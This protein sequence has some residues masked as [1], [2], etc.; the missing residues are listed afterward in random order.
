MKFFTSPHFDDIHPGSESD[1]KC[2]D[3]FIC[4]LMYRPVG[5]NFQ[6]GVR[7]LALRDAHLAERGAIA[8]ESLG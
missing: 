2:V 7:R 5:R 3:V 6:R 4:L 8:A 1:E